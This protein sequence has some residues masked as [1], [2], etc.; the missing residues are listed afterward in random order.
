MKLL[1]SILALT[2]VVSVLLTTAS[3]AAPKADPNAV[4]Q[5]CIAEAIAAVPAAPGMQEMEV[6]TNRISKYRACAKRMGFKP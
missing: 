4:R 2:F 6:Q 1:N 3:Q 5:K